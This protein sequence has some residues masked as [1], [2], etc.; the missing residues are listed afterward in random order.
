MSFRMLL[1]KA[2]ILLFVFISV[3]GCI[4]LRDY[5]S[6]SK[7]CAQM[8]V[9]MPLG[10]GKKKKGYLLI[11]NTIIDYGDTKNIVW[12]KLGRPSYFGTTL[13]GYELWRYDDKKVEIYFDGD[14]V[15][16]WQ[17]VEFKP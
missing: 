6:V 11:G 4:K 12:H 16:G 13:S 15:V 17:K 7:G 8:D 9:S 10:S 14:Y 1:T 2:I 3:S 5:I